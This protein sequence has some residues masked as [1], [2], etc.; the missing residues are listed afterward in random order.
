MYSIIFPTYNVASFLK[1]AILCIKAQTYEDW[2]LIIVDDASTDKSYAIAAK[3][4]KD[5]D[6]IRV[7]RHE[8]NRGVS[9]AR[10]TG[11]DAA[12]GEYILF[13]DPDDTVEPYLLSVLKKEPGK[14]D[15][16]LYSFHE[17]YFE[18]DVL[19]YSRRH[20]AKNRHLTAAKDIHDEVL[21]LERE[22]L[23]GY[24]WNKAYRLSFLREHG[25][26]FEEITHIEDILFNLDVMEHCKSL[27]TLKAPLYHYRNSGQIRLT[28]KYLPN[29]FVLQK[30]RVGAFLTQQKRWAAEEQNPARLREAR[31]LC[32]GIYFRSFL[33]FFE[34]EIAHK[35]KKNEILL[36]AKKEC[37]SPLFLEL[38]TALPKGK[39]TALLYAPLAKGNVKAAYRRAKLIH[40]VKNRFPFL[41]A[42]LKQKR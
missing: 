5:D 34:R 20:C 15:V 8:K 32:S 17:N 18:G 29:Y 27:T 36:R 38:C 23:L 9:A 12:K 41:Y 4:A 16:I 3:E 21:F 22:T 35:T 37:N 11:M 33:S 7:L 31:V 13:L 30:K 26:R 6:R 42:R 40:E 39:S 24:P 14:P 19:K 28:G 25:I 2:E 1:E 10:N